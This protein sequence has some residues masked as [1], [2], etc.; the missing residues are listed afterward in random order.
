[1]LNASIWIL[2][3][4]RQLENLAVERE[5]WQEFIAQLDFLTLLTNVL[6]Y[7][8]ALQHQV[9]MEHSLPVI[10]LTRH[11]LNPKDLSSLKHSKITFLSNGFLVVAR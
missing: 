1:M 8:P 6:K 3:G 7:Q 11:C 2:N 9:M 4:M 5:N 10:Q